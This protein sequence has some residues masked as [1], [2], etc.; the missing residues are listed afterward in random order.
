SQLQREMG[1]R[2][3]AVLEGRDIGTVVMP[4][5]RWKIYLVASLEERVNRRF[6]QYEQQGKPVDREQLRQ[7]I[8]DRDQQDRSRPQGALKLAAD[9]RVVE[10][11]STPLDAV[12]TALQAMIQQETVS[13]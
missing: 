12:V 2:G 1:L 7:D 6:H 5:A 11:T 8:L 10:S 3:R 13:V 4:E 9:A